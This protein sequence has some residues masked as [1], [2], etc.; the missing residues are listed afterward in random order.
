MFSSGFFKKRSIALA[1]PIK[2]NF[3]DTYLNQFMTKKLL[4]LPVI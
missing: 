1:L 2:T 4:L 3:S